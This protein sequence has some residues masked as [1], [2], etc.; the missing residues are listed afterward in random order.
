[1]I[2]LLWALAISHA[3]ADDGDW[4]RLHSQHAESSSYLKS[5]WNKYTENYHP[6]YILDG[7]PRTAW[8]EG[9]PGNGEGSWVEWP[10]SRVPAA[11][12]VKLRIRNGYHKSQSL[13]TANAAPGQVRID[14][15]SAGA[16]VH[17]HTAD[18]KRDLTWQEVVL[19]PAS[20][21]SMDAVRLTVLS[22][23]AG[24]SYADLCISDVE[25]F[26]DGDGTYSTA[27][28]NA[29]QQAANNWI[30]SRVRAA[31]AFAK[32]P[33][34]YPFK[35]TQFTAEDQKL[36]D[37]SPLPT[38]SSIADPMAELDALL[39]TGPWYRIDVRTGVPLPEGLEELG[40]VKPWFATDYGLFEAKQE[41][42]STKK[43]ID[44]WHVL[45][46]TTNTKVRFAPDGRTP[47]AIAFTQ[48]NTYEERSTYTK[49]ERVLMTFDAQ[50][51]PHQIF[52]DEVNSGWEICQRARK[53]TTI[54]VHRQD[55]KVDRIQRTGR[56]HCEVY[57]EGLDASDKSGAHAYRQIWTPLG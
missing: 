15:L 1:M 55:G 30:A 34:T 38:L 50:G 19:S 45:E 33:K 40:M 42:R 49:T 44:E 13:L 11:R 2:M 46:S 5:N 32:L 48:R 57:D 3:T 14:L 26:V 28:E 41:W 7:N 51:R 25:T 54:E 10:V 35:G 23:Q 56:E 22:A 53:Q 52:I 36:P 29:K 16:V 17:S 27:V 43:D 8:V 39:A 21:V 12:R 9:A 47:Q 31:E 18:L 37:N 24:R 6:T 20:A 4:K